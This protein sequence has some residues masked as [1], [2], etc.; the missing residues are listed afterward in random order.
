[1]AWLS[2]ALIGRWTCNFTSYWLQWPL[3]WNHNIIIVVWLDDCEIL[4]II[5]IFRYINVVNITSKLSLVSFLFPQNCQSEIIATIKSY[6]DECLQLQTLITVSQDNLG[7]SFCS[8]SVRVKPL[9]A[10]ILRYIIQIF[11]SQECLLLIILIPILISGFEEWRQS[12]DRM[13]FSYKMVHFYSHKT[14]K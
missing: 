3:L 8:L 12:V 9:I 5:C 13:I 1:M 14:Q 11:L 6:I 7:L 4:L 10:G 2:C